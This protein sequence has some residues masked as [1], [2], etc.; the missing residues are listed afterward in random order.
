MLP[1]QWKMRPIAIAMLCAPL[2]GSQ[3]D[4]TIRAS[5][6][7]ERIVCETADFYRQLYSR[8]EFQRLDPQ[9]QQD[10]K[11]KLEAFRAQRCPEILKELRNG[12]G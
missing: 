3:C 5:S 2:M 10:A 7:T 6:E 1:T 8:E 4:Q 9:T 11:R 12:R